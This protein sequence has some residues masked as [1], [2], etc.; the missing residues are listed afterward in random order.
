MVLG[1]LCLGDR[2]LGPNT[3]GSPCGRLE[4]GGFALHAEH[5]LVLCDVISGDPVVSHSECVSARLKGI[6]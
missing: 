3:T 5:L 1:D 6:P 4:L 2:L